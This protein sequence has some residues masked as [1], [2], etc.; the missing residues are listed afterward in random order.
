MDSYKQRKKREGANAKMATI[1][2]PIKH[3]KCDYIWNYLFLLP[4]QHGGHGVHAAMDIPIATM[5]PIV[6]DPVSRRKADLMISRNRFTHGW[7]YSSPMGSTVAVNGNPYINTRRNIG[8]YGLA[9]AMMLN[10][11]LT[12]KPNCIF[13]LDHIVTSRRIKMGEELTVHYGNAYEP[14]RVLKGYSLAKNRYLK[15][16]YKELDVYRYPP[17]QKRKEN[18]KYLHGLIRKCKKKR[19]K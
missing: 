18:I 9:I 17:V 11:P 6:G 7:V 14:I 3:N 10:E 5:I 16:A 8:S 4:M 1:M 12:K 2:Q 13:K 15:S 19:K